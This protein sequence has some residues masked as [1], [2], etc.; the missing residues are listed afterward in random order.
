MRQRLPNRRWS[1]T[2]NVECDGLTYVVTT[3]CFADGRTGE[4]FI[5]NNKCGSTADTNIRDA[6]IVLSLALQSGAD[7]ETMRRALCRDSNGRPSSPLGAALDMIGG[8]HDEQ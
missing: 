3:S 8:R 4:I 6:A 1:Q 5:T 2:F 7:I